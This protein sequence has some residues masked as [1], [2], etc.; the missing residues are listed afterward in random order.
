MPMPGVTLNHLSIE[1]FVAGAGIGVAVATG[2]TVHSTKAQELGCNG[3]S[4]RDRRSASVTVLPSVSTWATR[5]PLS[6]P[7][8]IVED[9]V[10]AGPGITLARGGGNAVP[11]QSASARETSVIRSGR[12]VVGT[13][14]L[15]PANSGI[16]RVDAAIKSGP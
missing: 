16:F 13:S 12:G 2:R 1:I 8:V 4:L 14:E 10:A 5:Q 7:R 15:R 3:R 6:L 11:L 9:L